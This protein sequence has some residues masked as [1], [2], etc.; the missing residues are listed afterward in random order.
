MHKAGDF[1]ELL[2]G[3]CIPATKAVE[4][5]N[6]RSQHE[7]IK[8]GFQYGGLCTKF[9]IEKECPK[10]RE[11]LKRNSEAL[12]GLLKCDIYINESSVVAVGTSDSGL[13][14]F[15]SIVECCFIKNEDPLI[16]AR[17][18]KLDRKVYRLM[19]KIQALC[20]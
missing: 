8:T 18:L 11:R 5:L 1:L 15:R 19:K 20:L 7:V 10:N 17:R 13:R 3:T 16:V 6:G 14:L 2:A 12:A 9:E 4:I